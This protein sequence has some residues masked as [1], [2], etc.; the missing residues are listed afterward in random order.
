[1]LLSELCITS[2]MIA[3][4]W[5]NPETSDNSVGRM[6]MTHSRIFSIDVP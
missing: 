5:D 6:Y 2:I 1:M 3:E 4:K